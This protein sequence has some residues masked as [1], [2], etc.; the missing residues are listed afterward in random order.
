MRPPVIKHDLDIT[1]LTIPY[2]KP[3]NLKDAITKAKLVHQA[4]G[5]EASKFYSGELPL[6][7][8]KLYTQHV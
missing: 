1:K 6:S 8:D 3:Q 5:R 4:S 7:A 2:S